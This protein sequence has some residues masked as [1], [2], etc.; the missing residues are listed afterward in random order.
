MDHSEAVEQMAAER[1]LLNEL[2]PELR[3][4]FEEHVF[5]CQECAFDLRAGAAFIDEARIQLP[6]LATPSA[7]ESQPDPAKHA[8]KKPKWFFWWQ[9]A[10]AAPAFAALLLV[11]GYQNLATIPSLR[12]AATQ[13]RLLPWVSLHA[14]TR[15]SAHIPVAADPKQ[16]AV[17]L[18]DLPQD[19]SYATYAFDLYDP[20]GKKLWSQSLPSPGDQ[21]GGD[22]T[23]SLLIP[24]SQLHPGAYTLAISGVN[25]GG[26]RTEIDRHVCDV[27]FDQ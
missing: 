8:V 13:P 11:I 9:P 26:D 12:S 23:I 17:I 10:F 6:E 14:G 15:G 5:D 4:A 2:A 3:D 22:K 19:T 7:A 1:Y 27:H 20:Q 21:S 16:G 24:G 25:S 18:I